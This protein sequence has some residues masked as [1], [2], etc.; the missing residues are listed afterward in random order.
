MQVE[1]ELHAGRKN[2]PGLGQP[3]FA[4][5]RRVPGRAPA[6]SASCRAGRGVGAAE[7]RTAS[8]HPAQQQPD[9]AG[10]G[11]MDAAAARINGRSAG[12]F[13]QSGNSRRITP[14]LSPLPRPV[15]TSTQ[16][17]RSARPGRRSRAAR[18]GRAARCGRAGRACAPARAC[19]CGTGSRWS[20]LPRPVRRRPGAEPGSGLAGARSA[21]RA[22][23]SARLEVWFRRELQGD[24][25]QRRHALHV[26][27]P[28]VPV[29]LR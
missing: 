6:R 26:I 1:F 12:P 27:G 10:I 9:R 15:I 20:G 16:R 19:R 11:G 21:E 2:Q 8:S 24:A 17:R 13:S 23:A 22:A 7:R 4:P 29:L 25:R 5:I 14:P 3:T 28:G 18:R